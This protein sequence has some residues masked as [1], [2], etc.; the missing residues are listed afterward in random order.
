[1]KLLALAVVAALGFL[2]ASFPARN[3]DVWGRLAAGRRL[4]AGEASFNADPRAVPGSAV[5]LSW[6]Y[7]LSSY[8]LYQKVGGA[9]LVFV[10]ALLAA[11]L[12][13]ALFHLSRA[14][15]GWW[16]PALG[17]ALA[18]LAMG[19]RLLLQPA[20]VSYLMLALTLLLLRRPLAP[21]GRS[22]DRWLPPWPLA[23]LFCASWIRSSFTA[24]WAA[25]HS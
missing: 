20:T 15:P 10:N 13:V 25:A 21:G 12:A 24:D 6:I 3:G 11:A 8:F 1:M 22:G 2:L 7:D 23:A 19:S 9:G 17:A 16:A 4:A 18:L 5:S 14:G